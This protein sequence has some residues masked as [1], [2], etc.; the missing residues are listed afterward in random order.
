MINLGGYYELTVIRLSDL[1]YMLKDNDSEVLLHFNQSLSEH[2]IND[3]VKVFI[4]ADK[5]KRLTATEY[6]PFIDLEKEGFVD[7]V[8]VLENTGVLVNINTPKDVL[9]TKDYLPYDNNLWP[10]KDDKILAKLKIKSNSFLAKPLSRYDIRELNKNVNY[11]E[12]EKIKAYVI[13][14]GESGLSLVSSDLMYIFVPHHQYRGVVR[15]GEEVLVTITKKTKDNEYYG[16]LNANKEDLIDNDKELIL[17]YIKDHHG[18]MKIT[19]KSDP[20]IIDRE[21]GLSKKAFK[22]AYGGLYKDRLIDFNDEETY[23]VK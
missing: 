9:L 16:K 23:L 21:F 6:S 10:K 1:G 8:D 3:K 18:K 19:E 15:M 2:K 4:Y 12:N 20:K 14:I 22:R 13:R 5:A 11:A 17:N 7:V